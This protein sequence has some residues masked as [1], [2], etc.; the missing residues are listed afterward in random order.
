MPRSRTTKTGTTKSGFRARRARGE[1]TERL[2]DSFF[3]WVRRFG[4]IAGVVVFILWIGAWLFLS[5]AAQ[6][7]GI[8]AKQ[9]V[10]QLAGHAGFAVENI[11]VEGRLHSDPDVLRALINIERGDPIFAF[12]P[13]DAKEMI[14]RISWVSEAHVERRLPDTIY[15]GLTERQPMALWQNKKKIRV[16]DSEGVTLTDRDIAP[17]K[18]L[19]IVVGE[20]APEHAPALLALLDAEPHVGEKVN[21]ATWLGERRWDLKLKNGITVKLPEDDMGLALRKLAQAQEQDRLL[22]K[23]LTVIDMRLPDRITVRT[24]PGAVQEYKAGLNGSSI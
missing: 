18:D 22:E 14:E 8:W 16:I 13:Q 20:D 2:R 6:R 24:R 1:K 19:I 12:D 4:K 11:L 5:G 17:Y 15:I 7:T 9:Q 23:D 21:A 3:L 10:Y